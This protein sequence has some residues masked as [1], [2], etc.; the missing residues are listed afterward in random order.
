MIDV[1]KCELIGIG[2]G[3]IAQ[4]WLHDVLLRHQTGILPFAMIIL[5]DGK[6]F[7]ESNRA[8]Q[9]FREPRNK[10]QELCDIWGRAYPRVPLR[11]VQK[12]VTADNVAEIIEEG[13]I[14]LLSPDNHATR[15]VVSD[16]IET[17]ENALLITGANDAISEETDGTE[18]IVLVHYKREGKDLT[19]PITRHHPKIASPVDSLPTGAGC[20]ELVHSAPQ[21]LRTNL[22]VGHYM[23]WLL[24][25]YCTR[26]P[27]EATKIVELWINSG[28]GE[29]ATYGI[30]ERPI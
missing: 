19:P 28:T 27:E 5:V 24:E 12:F 25:Q 4:G 2:T 26:P 1:S 10:A 14:V 9:Y 17:L 13:S 21:I 20:Q 30:G 8:R 23:A 11:H 15:K 3:G 6:S 22:M 18:G 29:V 7:R 16:H